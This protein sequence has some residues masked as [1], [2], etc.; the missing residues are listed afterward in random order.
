MLPM[1]MRRETPNVRWPEGKAFAFTIFD[2]PDG[3][4]YDDGRVVYSFLAD[5]GFRT[6]RGVWPGPAVRSP[7]SGGETCEN[8]RY[9]R[10]TAELQGMGFEVGYHNTTKH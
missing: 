4:S 7:N 3:Q 8:L 9:R 5:L 2:D 1:S 10:H 6:T